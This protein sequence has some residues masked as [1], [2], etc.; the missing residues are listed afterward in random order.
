MKKFFSALIAV[1]MCAVASTAFAEEPTCVMLRFTNDTRYKNVDSASVLSDLVLEKLLASG[2]FN[3][4]ETNPIDEDIEAKLYD[5]KARELANAAQS[6][7]DGNL[8]AL[9]EGP[10]FDPEQAQSI[11][12]AEAGQ[13]ISPEIT[14]QIGKDHGAEY[15][16]QGNVINLGNGTWIDENVDLASS[17]TDL[18][19]SSLGVP[20]FEGFGKTTAGIGIQ[21]E[22][23]IIKADTGKVVWKKV[24]MGKETKSRTDVGVFKFGSAKLTSEVYSQAMENT[25]QKI[26]DEMLKDLD[27][28][29]L[30]GE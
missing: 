24:V 15:I 25:V 16:I 29:K 12:N 4:V 20:G 10:G 23:R 3:F 1:V 6:M 19:S 18:A 26:V 21:S 7:E 14:A 5:V 17:L 27:D 9:F 11:K 30:F 8:N 22:L 2:K 13:I 28:N